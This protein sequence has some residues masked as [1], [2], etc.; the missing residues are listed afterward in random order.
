MISSVLLKRM[1]KGYV[2]MEF[3]VSCLTV[4]VQRDRDGGGCE[5]AGTGSA[6]LTPRVSTVSSASVTS[7]EVK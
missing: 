4:A 2:K 5:G 1:R 6:E 7:F 3:A